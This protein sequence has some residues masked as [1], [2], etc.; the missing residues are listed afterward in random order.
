MSIFSAESSY[1]SPDPL[2]EQR[3]GPPANAFERLARLPGVNEGGRGMRIFLVNTAHLGDCILALPALNRVRQAFPY[4]RIGLLTTSPVDSLVRATGLFDEVWGL[5][6]MGRL[7]YLLYWARLMPRIVGFDAHLAMSF[8]PDPE[9]TML[10]DLSGARVRIGPIKRHNRMYLRGHLSH[11][12]AWEFTGPSRLARYHRVCDEAG[13][14]FS[15]DLPLQTTDVGAKNCAIADG[16]VGANEGGCVAVLVCGSSRWKRWPLERYQALTRSI[17]ATGR[18]CLLITGPGEADIRS[19]VAA[20]AGAGVDHVDQLP[21][22][23]LL[24]VLRRCAAVVT[25]DSGPGHLAA[26]VGSPTVFMI[27]TNKARDFIP[28]GKVWPVVGVRM[29][30]IGLAEVEVQLQAALRGTREAAL[31]E[32]KAAVDG[33]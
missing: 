7:N 6:V 27:T 15:E 18:R 22:L 30:D 29:A 10:C 16:V 24:E 12:F 17:A 28:P 31:R 32:T 19:S 26:A 33:P 20:M 14:P 21:L 3:C 23:A 4:A 9:D 2:P 1:W 11:A 5:P 8:V 13:L 25:S